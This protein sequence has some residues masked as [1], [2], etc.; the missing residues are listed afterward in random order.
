MKISRL[1]SL[2]AL[3]ALLVVGSFNKVNA[4][5]T[6]S[7]QSVYDKLEKMVTGEQQEAQYTNKKTRQSVKVVIK[8]LDL[9]DRMTYSSIHNAFKGSEDLAVNDI[10]FSPDFGDGFFYLSFNLDDEETTRIVLLDVAGNE[11]HTETIE[12]FEGT[13][14]S[15][16]NIKASEKGT[17]FL[18]VIQG[19]SL[20]NKKLVIE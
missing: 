11:V 7:D 16:V 19:F 18:K 10:S 12:D 9:M 15:K 3:V 2:T 14:E 5:T 6:K 4:Q 20:L 17:Y 13:Y 8:D 1:L